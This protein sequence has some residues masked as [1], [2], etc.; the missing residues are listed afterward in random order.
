MIRFAS[1]GSG[2]KGNATLIEAGESP[3]DT[4]LLLDCGYSVVQVEKR[5]AKLGRSPKDI[6]AI[7]VT[8]EHSDHIVGVG[9]LSRKYKIPVWLT[10]GTW[11][12]SRDIDF[13]ETHFI[14]SHSDFDIQ[15]IHLHPFPVPHDAREP[16]QFVF[17]DGVSRLGIATDLG[18]Y[19]PYIVK[20]LS[21]LDALLLE[22]NYDFEMLMHGGYPQALKNRVSG[23]KG[24]LDNNQ[25]TRL[26]QSL[27]LSKLKHIV[28]MHVSEKNNLPEY[29]AKALCEGLDCEED[30][31]SLAS[32][33]DGFSWREIR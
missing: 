19:T 6:S 14:D 8:H 25:A 10:V 33:E 15:D 9:R 3:K 12:A 16:C 5:L 32:Q 7:V 4:R 21:H 29:A 31:V 17:S 13:A 18:C 11:N 27:E 1:L 20:H 26:L 28:G 22:C 23:Q 30:D 2:S 24:H